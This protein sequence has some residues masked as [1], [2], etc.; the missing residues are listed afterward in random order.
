M[1]IRLCLHTTTNAKDV[2]I[3]K[4]KYANVKKRASLTKAKKIYTG[5]A[6]KSNV[7]TFRK[8]MSRVGLDQMRTETS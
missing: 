3:R 8:L 5:A 4:Q 1:F 6:V 2:C 7:F